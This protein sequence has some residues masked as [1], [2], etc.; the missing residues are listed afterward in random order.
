VGD[1]DACFERPVGGGLMMRRRLMYLAAGSLMFVPI[2]M[3]TVGPAN[4]GVE[5]CKT[6]CLWDQPRF[7]G[8]MVE[9]TDAA[10]KD[11]PVKSAANNSNDAG[12]KM[13]IFFYKEPGC[14]GKPVNPYGLKAK[15]QS[16]RVDG[17]SATVKPP[18]R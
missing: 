3:M 4:A 5:A 13:A 2:Q 15:G 6:W 9:L 17:V 16:P 1:R 11:F 14:Q 8:N 18:T 12:G 10:C 7:G